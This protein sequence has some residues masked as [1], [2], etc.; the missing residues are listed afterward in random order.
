V[1]Q[2]SGV[3]HP[4]VVLPREVARLARLRDALGLPGPIA[5][6]AYELMAQDW[7]FSSAKARRE[8]G[9]RCR[10]LDQTLRT[11]ID[12]YTDLIEQRV[13]DGA[14]R[15]SL[16]TLA[17]G[18]RVLSRF[19]VLKPFKLGQRLVGRRVIAGV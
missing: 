4:V 8:L 3:H 19:G 14:A 9:Y 18:T 17:A 13:F 15:S 10:P 11:T 16:S 2:L 1:A 6:E 7:R 5:A 12:W